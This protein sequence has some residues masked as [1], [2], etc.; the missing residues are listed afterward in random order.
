VPALGLESQA[1]QPALHIHLW[2][3]HMK[4]LP[5]GSASSKRV[6]SDQGG[7]GAAGS[8]QGR[9]EGKYTLDAALDQLCKFHNIPGREA[10][11]SMRQCWFMRELE[12]RTQ[13]LPGASQAQ[14]AGG[15]EDQQHEPAADKPD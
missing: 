9:K 1:R 15:Q 2:L 11:H 14:P 6:A 8:G 7:P 5:K 10:T 4:A 12:Q 3:D 13:Q